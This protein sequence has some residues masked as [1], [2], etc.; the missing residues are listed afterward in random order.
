M[1]THR[2]ILLAIAAV[3]LAS[4]SFLSD[5]AK[6]KKERKQDELSA[7]IN[8]KEK[9]RVCATTPIVADVVKRVGKEHINVISLMGNHLDPHA[10]NIVKGDQ[11][12]LLKADIIFANGLFLEHTGSMQNALAANKEKVVYLSDAIPKER[13]IEINGSPDPHFWMDLK[14]WSETTRLINEKLNLKDPENEKKYNENAAQT[15]ST[16]DSLDRTIRSS[17]L[18]IPSKS[19]YL[20]TSHDAFNYYAR[21]YLGKEGVWRDRFIAI[22]GLAPDEQISHSEI[23]RVVDYMMKYNVQVI[24]A[25]RNLSHDSLNKVIDSCKRLGHKASLAKGELYGD[26]P[27]IKTYLQ[28]MQINSDVINE[29]LGGNKSDCGCY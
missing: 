15:R 25:E 10:Y 8:E 17:M 29:N 7:W 11:E 24:F 26:T 22:Q 1:A 12:K 14:L 27:G 13:I 9:L 2:K 23:R 18:S 28:M 19:R 6:G 16:F 4:C 21:A 20:V 3:I 5:F